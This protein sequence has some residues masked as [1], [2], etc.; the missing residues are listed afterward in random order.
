MR[1][2]LVTRPEPGADRTAR[3]LA[4]LGLQPV[5]LPLTETVA[6]PAFVD[7][8]SVFDA[9][10]LTSAEA[11]RHASPAL[12]ERLSGLSCFA[13]GA[14]TAKAARSAGFA[15]VREGP[16]DAQGLANL[17]RDAVPAGRVAYLCGRVRMPDFEEKLR[18]A[19]LHVSP[20]ETYDTLRIER[21]GKDVAAMAA[22]GPIDVVLLYSATAAEGL[23]RLQSNGEGAELFARSDYFCL[24]HR[25]AA[26]LAGVAPQNIRIAASPTEDA[27][28]ALLDKAG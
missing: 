23:A 27:L 14:R 9:V 2:V 1:R 16:G 11:I 21:G 7:P 4:R 22:S 10:A 5:V 3:R 20:V 12:L 24:S 15:V 8:A 13:V 6:L 26:A 28:L 17:V 19:G 18:T 25:V